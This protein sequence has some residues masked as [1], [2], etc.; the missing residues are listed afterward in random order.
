MNLQMIGEDP[1]L[2][3]LV[4]EIK[5]LNG[6]IHRLRSRVDEIQ[7]RI[8]DLELKWVVDGVIEN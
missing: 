5:R 8:S 1:V 6:E 3:A 2:E 4:D 7:R